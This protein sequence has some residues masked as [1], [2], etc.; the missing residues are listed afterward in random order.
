MSV[1]RK[2]NFGDR[3]IVTEQRADIFHNVK[4]DICNFS[5][6]QPFQDLATLKCDR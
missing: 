3:R 5:R 1:L 4:A 6:A 2:I